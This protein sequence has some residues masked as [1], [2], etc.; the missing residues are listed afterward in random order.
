MKKV[1]GY[2]GG[3]FPQKEVLNAQLSSTPLTLDCAIPGSCL[4]NCT[5][6]GYL[7]VNKEK[8]LNQDEIL[9]AFEEFAA[10]GGKSIKILGEGEPMLRNDILILLARIHELRMVPVLFTCGDVLGS[11]ALAQKIHHIS[12][13]EIVR[14]LYDIGVTVMLKY[15]KR[16]QDDIVQRKGFSTL[17]NT[18][19]RHLLNAGFNKNH[20]SRLGFGIVL[21]KSNFDE[22]PQT[23]AFALKN[24]IYPLVCPLMPI[25]RVA[26]QLERERLSPTSHEISTLTAELISLRKQ[27]GIVF[28]DVSAFP[29]GKP[30][31]VARAGMYMDDIGNIKLCEADD[32]VGNIRE[33]SLAE[34]WQRCSKVKER[35]YGKERWAGRCFPKINAGILE[36]S[37]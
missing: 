1:F 31:D 36:C 6:C 22:L 11:D 21:L 37:C 27:V 23:F 17:R 34:L 30:C 35:K 2:L 12:C 10:M 9:H 15:E 19:L 4:N 20:P 33:S 32:T 26:G 8:K 14:K 7:G 3:T 25:G 13:D 29:G 28:P 24:N 18:V 5:Y 16:E